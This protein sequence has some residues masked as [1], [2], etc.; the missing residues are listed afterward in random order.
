[1]SLKKSDVLRALQRH[2]GAHKGVHAGVLVRKIT[3]GEFTDAHERQLRNIITQLRLEG[4]H[5][6]AT[7]DE[8]YFMAATTDELNHT[9]NFLFARALK[10]LEQISRMKNVSLPDLRGQLRLPY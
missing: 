10:S 9:C 2:I 6:C 3:G 1:M 4:H 5:I 8:G 7:P